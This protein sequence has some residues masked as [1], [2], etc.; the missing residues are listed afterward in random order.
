MEDDFRLEPLE[1][2]I[3]DVYVDEYNFL[4]KVHD[5]GARDIIC[6]PDGRAQREG[7]PYN[8]TKLMTSPLDPDIA[9]VM[10]VKEKAVRMSEARAKLA[11]KKAET[12]EGEDPELAKIRQQKMQKLM[13]GN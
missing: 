13:K 3:V 8:P 5:E 4:L 7:F 6:T 1:P 2:A 11:E 10:L 9:L 12:A